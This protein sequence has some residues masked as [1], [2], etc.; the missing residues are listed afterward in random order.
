MPSK[1]NAAR[2]CEQLGIPYRLAEY[3][4]GEEHL[5]AA[6]VAAL[7][8]QPAEQVFKTLVA[9]GDRTGVLLA[10]LPAPV[11]LDLKKLAAA[12][13]NKRVE[14]VDLAEVQPLTGY[15]RGGVSPLGA[16]RPFPVFI[17]ETV[18]MWDEISV[19]AG[20]RGTQLLIAPAGLVRAV[21]ATLADLTQ[22]PNRPVQD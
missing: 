1:T 10:C 15:V 4:V 8:G 18:E 22:L 16:R 2:I 13:G 6:E 9:R 20:Q 21:E 7:I 19:S 3:P 17:D 14:L 11:E 12:S 5:S